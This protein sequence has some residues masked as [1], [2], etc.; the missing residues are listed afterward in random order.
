MSGLLSALVFWLGTS[1]AAP[2]INLPSVA[3]SG[4]GTAVYVGSGAAF[5]RYGPLPT[6]R[7][8]LQAAA[9]SFSRRGTPHQTPAE[10]LAAFMEAS[11]DSAPQA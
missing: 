1:W 2:S 11:L 7:V 9:A 10:T 5:L 3:N 4:D 6:A 8:S